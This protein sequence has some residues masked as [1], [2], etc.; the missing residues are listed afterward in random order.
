MARGR[1]RG[2]AVGAP[3]KVLIIAPAAWG[4]MLAAMLAACFTAPGALA[5]VGAQV[6]DGRAL[7]FTVDYCG[8]IVA[9][10]VLRVEGAE[11]VIV[12]AAGRLDGVDLIPALLPHIEDRFTGCRAIRFHTERPGLARLMAAAGYVGQEVV[13]RKELK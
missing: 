13:M 12:A 6:E 11:G 7:A 1:L 4:E 3:E 9:A 5:T 10:F 2:V 8:E